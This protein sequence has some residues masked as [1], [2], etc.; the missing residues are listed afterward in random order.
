MNTYK[1]D[2]N[3][4]SNTITDFIEWSYSAFDYSRDNDG[5]Y[6]IPELLSGSDYSGCSVTKANYN[7]FL[8]THKDQLGVS[9]WTLF[10]GH[11][12]YGIA[13]DRKNLTE[14]MQADLDSLEDYCRLSDD[15]V[16][17]VEYDAENEAWENYIRSDFESALKK[18]FVP[19]DEE[20]TGGI[21]EKIDNAS[22]DTLWELFHDAM[23]KSNTYFE[24]ETGGSVYVDIERVVEHI[25]TLTL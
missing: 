5:Q 20:Y 9:M 18:K 7:V 14:D 16:C 8:D 1:F 3:Y 23:E 22:S 4:K 13:I 2:G 17:Q 11:G 6:I 19:A 25:D 10:G 24:H 15:E 12:T 21:E